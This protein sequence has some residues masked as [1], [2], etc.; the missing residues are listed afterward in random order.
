MKAVLSFI[1]LILTLSCSCTHKQEH[2]DVKKGE[3]I[4][5]TADWEEYYRRMREYDAIHS[6]R[7]KG[8][9]FEDGRTWK[10]LY[11]EVPFPDPIIESVPFSEEEMVI[12]DTELEEIIEENQG[13]PLS[14]PFCG[15]IDS[16]FEYKANDGKIFSIQLSCCRSLIV[17]K[18]TLKGE[19][20]TK[21]VECCVSNELIYSILLKKCPLGA[22]N[23]V[24]DREGKE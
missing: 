21:V 9:P 16:Q 13:K 8:S 18:T 22:E 1:L 11:R 15:F 10:D 24:L 20:I 12:L 5:I 2:V 17:V 19:T 7:F 6:D 23:Q 4:R 14:I 3:L